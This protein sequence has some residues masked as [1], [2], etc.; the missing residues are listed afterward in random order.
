VTFL[1]ALVKGIEKVVRNWQVIVLLLIVQ[2][3][4]ACLLAAPMGAT[5]HKQWDHSM[6]GRQLATDGMDPGLYRSIWDETKAIHGGHLGVT[7]DSLLMWLAGILY[8]I[9]CILIIAGALPLY[10]GLDLKFTWDRFWVNASRYFRSYVGLAIL[11]GI[12][13]FAADFAAL[14]VDSLIAEAGANSDDEPM[15]FLT[16]VVLTG[17]F[18][19]L[20]FGLIVLV[21]Q[22]AKVVAAAES[23]RN[24]IYLVRKAFSFVSRHFLT[25]VLLFICLGLI[26]LGINALDTAVWYYLMPGLE[27]WIQWSWLIAVTA[28][29]VIVKLSMLSCQLQL[30]VEIRR[31]S[32]DRWR[33]QLDSDSYATEY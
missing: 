3:T 10:T 15:V 17:G 31:R 27:I 25:A 33:V 14:T 5:L 9:V 12:L 21:F 26:D 1:F 23:L 11:A 24:I 13:F 32:G 22:Y 28:L 4:L 7:Y 30:F 19:F 6:I 20:L 18:R 8:V 2:I 16:G 29:L